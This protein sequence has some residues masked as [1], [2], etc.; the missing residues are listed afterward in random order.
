ML[1]AGSR[2]FIESL[3]THVGA[4]AD[5]SIVQILKVHVK[6]PVPARSGLIPV[7]MV[8]TGHA[9]IFAYLFIRV[10]GS[11]ITRSRTRTMLALCA[12]RLVEKLVGLR[13]V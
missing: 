8:Y 2:R 5:E 3:C 4:E 13:V 1:S 9:I 7:W 11:A 12:V 10:C 6:V